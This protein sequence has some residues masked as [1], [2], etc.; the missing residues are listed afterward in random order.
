MTQKPKPKPRVRR[1]TPEQQ[2]ANFRALA[3]ELECDEDEE[4]FKAKVRKVATAPKP[5]K[6]AAK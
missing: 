5:P 2:V 3:R 1:S 4:A 6:T